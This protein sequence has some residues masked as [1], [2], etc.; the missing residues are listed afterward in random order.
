MGLLTRDVVLDGTHVS[1]F[2]ARGDDVFDTFDLV[3]EYICKLLRGVNVLNVAS[4]DGYLHRNYEREWDR[5]D[6]KLLSSGCSGIPGGARY[7]DGAKGASL[8]GISK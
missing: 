2:F 6:G 7:L 1:F 5:L 4:G 8:Y 3:F